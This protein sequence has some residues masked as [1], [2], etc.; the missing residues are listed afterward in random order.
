METTSAQPRD[1]CYPK[2][3]KIP[4]MGDENGEAGYPRN[5]FVNN[6]GERSLSSFLSCQ[7]SCAI[8]VI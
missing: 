2:Y 8:V 3:E 1:S 5:P 4:D 7:L 6:P